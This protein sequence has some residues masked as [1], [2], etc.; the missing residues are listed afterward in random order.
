MIRLRRKRG[1]HN[2]IHD[3]PLTQSSCGPGFLASL[4][5]GSNVGQRL[6]KAQG[7]VD[8]ARHGGCKNKQRDEQ[9]LHEPHALVTQMHPVEEPFVA[10]V[11]ALDRSLPGRGY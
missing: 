1:S 8:P 7:Q 3:L 6:E 10:A 5:K 11:D 9:R 2:T 4:A